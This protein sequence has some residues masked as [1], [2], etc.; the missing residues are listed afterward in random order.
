[1]TFLAPVGRGVAPS[2]ARDGEQ[3]FTA[4]GCAS[5]HTP[6]LTTGPSR[7]PVFDRKPVPLFSDL[8]LHDIG[9]GD[10]IAQEAAQPGEIRTPALWGLRFR[11]PLL[12]DGSAMTPFDAINRHGGEAAG[13][14]EN[15]RRA[16]DQMRRA[17]FAFLDSL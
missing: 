14:M 16:S 8:L 11:R 13:V 2:N 15:Y 5:C 7:D 6:L 17:L 4:I 3:V 10:G 9:T 1:M 12:H